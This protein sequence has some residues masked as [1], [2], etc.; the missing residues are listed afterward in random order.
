MKRCRSRMKTP[1]GCSQLAIGANQ[2]SPLALW[3]V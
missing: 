3:A 2:L 1:M